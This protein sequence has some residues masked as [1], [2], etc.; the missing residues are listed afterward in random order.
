CTT[1]LSLNYPLSRRRAKAPCA[2]LFRFAA[3][4]RAFTSGGRG[5]VGKNLARVRVRVATSRVTFH[6]NGNWPPLGSGGRKRD[7]LNCQSR[8][9]R[10]RRLAARRKRLASRSA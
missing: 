2:S 6:N 5:R 9:V 1:A 7:V 10:P 4:R 3:E 8:R